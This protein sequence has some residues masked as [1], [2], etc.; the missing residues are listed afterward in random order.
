[1]IPGE[2]EYHA[3]T[4]VDE[5]VAL[6]DR[7]GE[8]AKVLAGGHSLIPAMRFRLAAPEHLVDING[9]T[10]LSYVREE[11]GHLLIGAMT[12]ESEV[13]LSEVV[14]AR[15]HLLAAAPRVIAAGA[16]VGGI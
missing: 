7:L 9:I 1:M 8:G 3:A 4:S 10:D 11:G 5:A 15:Y 2:F 14:V 13:E 6:L 12:R 16:T